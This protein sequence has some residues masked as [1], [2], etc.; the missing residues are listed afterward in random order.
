[1]RKRLGSQRRRSQFE[2]FQAH[3]RF[4]VSILLQKVFESPYWSRG[5][6]YAWFKCQSISSRESFTWYITYEGCRFQQTFVKKSSF[7]WN[8]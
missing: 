2:A 8:V 1:M 6:Y 5:T 7:I 4:K 3:H